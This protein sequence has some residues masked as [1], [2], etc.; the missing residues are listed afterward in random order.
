MAVENLF[1][2]KN[3]ERHEFVK[4]AQV[5]LIREA[6]YDDIEVEP[7]TDRHR[8]QRR[9]DIR[10]ADNT[11][12]AKQ[13]HYWIDHTIGHT[14]CNTYVD[15]E[16]QHAGQVLKDLEKAKERQYL[17]GLQAERAHPV[18]SVGARAVIYRTV[19]MT[20]LGAI[21]DGALKVMN[22]CT[23]FYK[24][25]LKHQF[26]HRPRADGKSIN[27]LVPAYRLRFRREMQFAIAHGNA[28]IASAA[29]V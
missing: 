16:Y 8:N 23:S 18:V 12:L 13:I 25:Q 1:Q 10:F 29:G 22:A 7:R 20:S 24:L 21:G 14:L 11:C 15:R 17:D 26:E 9:A 28:L 5:G 3:L 6:G 2:Q 27:T 4:R 19:A